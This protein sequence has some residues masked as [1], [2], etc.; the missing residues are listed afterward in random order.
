AATAGDAPRATTIIEEGRLLARVRHPNVVTIYGAERIGD[1][2]G[3]W[4]EFVK[5]GTLAQAI[6]QGRTFSTPE[7]CEIGMQLCSAVAAVH[8]AGLLHRDIKAQNVMLTEEGRLVLM[9]FGT[10]RELRDGLP[11]GLAGTPLYL[12]PEL[13]A[14][15]EP[16][17]RSDIY[18]VGVLLYHL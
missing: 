10:G 7:V 5:G 8:A 2:V 17:V 3:M 12:A 18:S 13:L 15:A 16:S 4:M 11:A 14:G 1:Q 9:D 6:E